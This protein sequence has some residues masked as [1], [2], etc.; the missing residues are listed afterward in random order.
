MLNVVKVKSSD[1]ASGKRKQRETKDSEKK[2]L[3]TVSSSTENLFS[4]QLPQ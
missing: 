2:T 4:Q 3:T 1:L